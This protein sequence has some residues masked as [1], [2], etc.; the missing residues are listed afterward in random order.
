MKKRFAMKIECFEK[1]SA[2]IG[3]R[4]KLT[5]ITRSIGGENPRGSSH[6]QKLVCLWIDI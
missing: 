2:R 6:Y 5:R 4:R 3:R 1:P